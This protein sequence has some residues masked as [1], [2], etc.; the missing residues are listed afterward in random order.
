MNYQQF[1]TKAFGLQK[2]VPVDIVCKNSRY[3]KVKKGEIILNE[4]EIQ[5]AIPL[6]VSGAFEGMF[7][8]L[9]GKEHIDCIV[10]DYGDAVVGASVLTEPSPVA[11]RALIP[12][13]IICVPANVVISL[14]RDYAEVNDLYV[15][16]SQKAVEKHRAVKNMLYQKDAIERYCWFLDNYSNVADKLSQKKIA[17][18]LGITEEWLSR[19]K[20]S[21]DCKRRVDAQGKEK[22][23]KLA[24]IGKS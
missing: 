10:S 23:E 9:D 4:G 20:N 1:Y 22:E 5:I 24:R 12:S 13:E 7:C 11:I 17:A 8:S 3:Q 21:E 6:L 18:F 14:M 15:R 2:S 19:V 16:M